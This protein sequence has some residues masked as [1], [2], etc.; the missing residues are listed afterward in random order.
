MIVCNTDELYAFLVIY[1]SSLLLKFMA[2][3]GLITHLV[4]VNYQYQTFFKLFQPF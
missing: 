1:V 2:E 3:K 4:T